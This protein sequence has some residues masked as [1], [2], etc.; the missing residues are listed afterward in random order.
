MKVVLARKRLTRTQ[1]QRTKGETLA[2]ANG[3]RQRKVTAVLST[4][5]YSGKVIQKL[6]T[7]MAAPLKTKEWAQGDRGSDDELND[8]NDLL[9]N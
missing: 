6:E 7:Q 8:I 2:P 1:I 9:D 4:G 3:T 5:Y